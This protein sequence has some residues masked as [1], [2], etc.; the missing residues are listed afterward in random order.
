[1][2]HWEKKTL[3]IKDGHGWTARP[4][5]NVLVADRGAVRFD[6]PEDWLVV[7]D[8]KGSLKLHDR[9]PPDDDCT[10]QMTVFYLNPEI[11][12]GALPLRPLVEKLLED[13]SRFILDRGEVVAFS[14]GSMEVAWAEVRFMDPVEARP[15]FS[16]MCLARCRDIQPLITFDYWENDAPRCREIWDTVMATLRLGE[17]IADPSMGPSLDAEDLEQ[18][19]VDDRGRMTDDR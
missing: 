7:P 17:T 10:L 1:M 18:A 15:A 13:D 14:R 19:P 16:R 5:C 2:A 8:E 6:Y 3:P 9:Q 4:G 12:W 11:D